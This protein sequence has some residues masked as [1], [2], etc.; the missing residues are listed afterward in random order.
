M[1][2]KT[3]PFSA[4]VLNYSEGNVELIIT[5]SIFIIGLI[6][7][8]TAFMPKDFWV[9]LPL[10]GILLGI[11]VWGLASSFLFGFSQ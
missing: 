6:A 4:I 7:I 2:G 5:V 8:L 11:L 1:K 3:N 9:N 10:A